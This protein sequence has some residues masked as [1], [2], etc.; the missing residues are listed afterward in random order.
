MK[1]AIDGLPYY[2]NVGDST[3]YT[4]EL[5]NNIPYDSNLDINIVKDGEIN[6]NIALKNNLGCEEL[7]IN[8]R[9]EDYKVL[10]DYINNSSTD[11]FHCFNNGFSLPDEKSFNSKIIVSLNNFVDFQYEE[12]YR[13][14][15]VEKYYASINRVIQQADLITC[16]NKYMVDRICKTTG[17][18]EKKVTTLF[19]LINRIYTKINTYMSKVYLKSKF[20]ILEDFILYSGDLHRRKRLDE[21][22]ELF[23]KISYSLQ[24]IKFIMLSNVTS[25]NYD[26]YSEL[27]M[28]IRSL[29]LENR[30]I[31]ISNYTNLDK[32]HF[33]N[34]AKAVIDF[35]IVDF[36]NISLLE[37][38]SCGA[39]IICSDLPIYR[40][41]LNSYPYYLELSLPL[42]DEIIV[43]IIL[44]NNTCEAKRGGSNNSLLK[45][46]YNIYNDN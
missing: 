3:L 40:E 19:P 24:D 26:Y 12:Y 11:I 34:R 45:Y 13:A 5:V 46:Y 6:S 30:I 35:S 8:R 16:P 44:S 29:G 2:I 28:L 21:V 36:L 37:A 33:Y 27:T 20:N 18:N 15:Y 42:I 41:Y 4:R 17:V 14:K 22:I 43:D 31:I 10:V 25:L 9:I 39:T 7:Y 38:M 1:V 32:L 23:M